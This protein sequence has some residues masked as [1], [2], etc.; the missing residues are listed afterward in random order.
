MNI[1]KRLAV[2]LLLSGLMVATVW[3][4][5]DNSDW[6][7]YFYDPFVVNYE[8]NITI[9]LHNFVF[10]NTSYPFN[11]EPVMNRAWGWVS[12]PVN[13]GEVNDIYIRNGLNVETIQGVCNHEL[14]HLYFRTEYPIDDHHTMMEEISA[15]SFKDCQKL[16][17]KLR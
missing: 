4:V 13:I 3:L 17:D 8:G 5:L 11:G 7:R 1:D 12:L 10:V 9:G 14:M 15:I 6:G 16:A 2:E